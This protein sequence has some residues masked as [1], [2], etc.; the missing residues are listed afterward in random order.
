VNSTG[1]GN[2]NGNAACS[3]HLSHPVAETTNQP[4]K[5]ATIEMYAPSS[6]ND[7]V[8]GETLSSVSEK[9]ESYSNEGSQPEYIVSLLH[10]HTDTHTQTHILYSGF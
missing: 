2:G 9:S 7:T 3:I 1:N 10:T 4:G 6:Y 5:T 8:T